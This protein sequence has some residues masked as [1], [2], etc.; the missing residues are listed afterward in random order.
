M[1]LKR[2]RRHPPAAAPL[3]TRPSSSLELASV[4]LPVPAKHAKW[5][6]EGEVRTVAEAALARLAHSEDLAVVAG[7]HG[8]RGGGMH[9]ESRREKAVQMSRQN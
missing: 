2:K 9:Q 7:L 6:R 1:L 8:G 4:C 5:V 3:S